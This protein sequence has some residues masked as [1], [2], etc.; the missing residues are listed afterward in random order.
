METAELHALAQAIAAELGWQVPYAENHDT[1]GG[2]HH[3]AT[4]KPGTTAYGVRLHIDRLA[5]AHVTCSGCIP[6]HD[7]EGSYIYTSSGG[8]PSI[9]VSQKKSPAHMAREIKRRLLPKYDEEYRAA[10][11]RVDSY[12][13]DLDERDRIYEMLS[14]FGTPSQSRMERRGRIYLHDRGHVTITSIGV[15]V[16]VSC[17]PEQAYHILAFLRDDTNERG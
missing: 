10:K 4:I 3:A 6:C 7:R 1:H 12:N 14:E 16:Q 13:A 2:L 5:R 9:R 8:L 17:T 15:D 11:R